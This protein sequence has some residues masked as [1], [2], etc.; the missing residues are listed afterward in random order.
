MLSAIIFWG[1]FL[2]MTEKLDNVF[3]FSSVNL[4]NFPNFLNPDFSKMFS[5]LHPKK[6][7]KKTWL[8]IR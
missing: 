2:F 7:L 3:F 4:T 5:T 8:C 1:Q 6:T